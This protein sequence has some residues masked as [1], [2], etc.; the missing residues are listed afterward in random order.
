MLFD[1]PFSDYY[2]ESDFAPSPEA[3]LSPAQKSLLYRLNQ[4]N[5]HIKGFEPS[6]ALLHTL[7]GRVGELEGALAAPES[8]TRQPAE[9]EDSGLFLEEEDDVFGHDTENDAVDDIAITDGSEIFEAAEI[10]QIAHN[11]VA[12]AQAKAED[13]WRNQETQELIDRVTKASNELRLRYQEIKHTNELALS[14]LNAATTEILALRSENESL[15]ADTIFD[16]SKLLFLKLQLKT[17]EA[18]SLPPFDHKR[19]DD[20]N[21]T[22]LSGIQRWKHDWRTVNSRFRDRKHRYVEEGKAIPIFT[23]S[24]QP[25]IHLVEPKRDSGIDFCQDPG[26][27]PKL[28]VTR[29]LSQSLERTASGFNI[30]FP[31]PYLET[32]EPWDSNIGSLKSHL[33]SHP[34]PTSRTSPSTYEDKSTQVVVE[35]DDEE[36]VV[37]NGDEY[38]LTTRMAP[39]STS[40][41]AER[42]R[43][44]W[45]ELVD[46]IADFTGFNQDYEDLFQQDQFS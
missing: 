23:G 12:E 2:T 35:T 46:G 40:P 17:L 39:Q 8:Q 7:N 42:P 36:T 15:R 3:A 16:Y 21:E 27:T 31:L 29:E 37:A 41:R 9:L 20:I 25:P 5:E 45:Q 6:D 32:L 28:T 10:A 22:I 38:K 30:T 1:S 19:H 14:K 33:L 44:A 24:R 18:E 26:S 43:T 4:I 13:I 34:R 11:E